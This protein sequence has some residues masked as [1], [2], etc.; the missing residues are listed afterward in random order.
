MSLTTESFPE[1]FTT[2]TR[3]TESVDQS[4]ARARC[5]ARLAAAHILALEAA[6]LAKAAMELAITDW[7]SANNRTL[8]GLAREIAAASYK[9]ADMA[10]SAWAISVSDVWG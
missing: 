5:I 6:V 9:A 7:D 10:S 4:T 8:R 3:V 2:V 1:K